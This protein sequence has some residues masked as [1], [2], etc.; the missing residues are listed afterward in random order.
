MPC[1]LVKIY[2]VIPMHSGIG[3]CSERMCAEICVRNEGFVIRKI[4][5]GTEPP[6]RGFQIETIP[7]EQFKKCRCLYDPN[8]SL[9]SGLGIV[10]AGMSN[11]PR[12]GSKGLSK[13]I[14]S[15]MGSGTMASQ[16]GAS[17][18]HVCYTYIGVSAPW[19]FPAYC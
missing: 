11:P 10:P 14:E 18:N 8:S 9:P 1:Q 17:D 3:N 19:S 2:I 15:E 6:F 4:A 16:T 13:P 5:D 7:G 12:G